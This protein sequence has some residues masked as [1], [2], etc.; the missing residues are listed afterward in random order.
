MLSHSLTTLAVTPQ[1]THLSI[2]SDSNASGATN[3]VTATK[4]GEQ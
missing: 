3:S 2:V 1:G 4:D